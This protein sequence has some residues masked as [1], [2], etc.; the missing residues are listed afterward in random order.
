MLMTSPQSSEL[1]ARLVAIAKDSAWL[2]AALRAV[3]QLQLGSWCS[4]AGAVR[5]LVWDAL[6]A[7]PAPSSL[8]DIDV[9]F[10]D[11]TR[12]APEYEA[13]LQ[14]RLAEIL[15][16]A[17]W[18]VSN[19]AAVHLWFEG[20]FGHAVPP[21]SSLEDAVATWPEYATAVG[22]KLEDDDS[23]S[24]I[25]PHGLEDL[26]AMVVRHN[27]TRASVATY[28]QRVAQKRYTARWPRV[29]VLPC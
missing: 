1:H 27:R 22:L 7:F 8:P 9:A 18:E 15:P 26:F 16:G 5:N 28:R 23:I 6:H 10:F 21:L 19:Q 2:M 25:A 14:E 13:Q 17:P 12:L 11:H 3:R 4:G 20:A 29:T 24:V